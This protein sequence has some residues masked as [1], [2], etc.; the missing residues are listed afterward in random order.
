MTDQPLVIVL[1]FVQFFVHALGWAMAS[2]LTGRWN[3][4]EGHFAACRLLL[5]VGLMLYVPAWPAGSFPRNA[6]GM[7]VVA[8]MVIQHRGMALY[9]GQRPSDREYAALLADANAEV[10]APSGGP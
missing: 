6:R 2:N 9:W 5:A 1:V 7:L 4:S 8:A 3:C 10:P